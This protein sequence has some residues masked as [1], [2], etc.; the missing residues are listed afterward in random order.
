MC[1]EA[2]EEAGITI[3]PENLQF[4][5]VMHRMA[6]EER[7]DFFFIAKSWEGTPTNKEPEKCDDLSWFLLLDLPTNIIPYVKHA[8]EC[9]IAKTAYSEFGWLTANSNK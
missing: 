2:S 7:I 5:H 8:I 3:K 6:E 4:A 9:Y 1:R